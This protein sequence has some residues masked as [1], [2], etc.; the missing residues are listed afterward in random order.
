MSREDS[1]RP[2]LPALGQNGTGVKSPLIPILP[3]II[4][5]TTVGKVNVK[6]GDVK[7]VTVG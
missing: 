2:S 6:S 7:R 4:I 5:L 1:N 3:Q